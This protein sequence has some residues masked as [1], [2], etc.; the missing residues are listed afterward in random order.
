MDGSI[1]LGPGQRKRL[2]AICRGKEEQP[3]NVRLRAHII[4]LLSDGQAWSLIAT[5]LFCLIFPTKNVRMS[6]RFSSVAPRR[7]PG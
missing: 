5:V 2:L 3:A 1:V 6:V 7:L 4:L